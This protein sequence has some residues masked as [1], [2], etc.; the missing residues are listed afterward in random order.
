LKAIPAEVINQF[1]KFCSPY[2]LDL[3]H[4][5]RSTMLAR[6]GE[7][8]NVEMPEKADFRV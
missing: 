8:E 3:L 5:A 2:V 7:S 6:I 1:K 4:F